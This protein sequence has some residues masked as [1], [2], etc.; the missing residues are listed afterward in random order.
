MARVLAQV[1]A[2]VPVRRFRPGGSGP[3]V[4]ARRFRLGGS[5]TGYGPEVLAQRFRHGSSGPEV[6]ARRFR[7]G[8]SSTGYGPEVP[9]QR[10]WHIRANFAT[11]SWEPL[12]MLNLQFVAGEHGL[13]GGHKSEDIRT[14]FSLN[15]NI[16]L[17]KFEYDSRLK[18][19][20]IKIVNLNSTYLNFHYYF[21]LGQ[22]EPS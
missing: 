1:P 18:A 2:R 6:P 9:A 15:F 22:A 12:A 10:F 21:K 17:K 19:D 14:F 7:H 16:Q 4:P 13:F 11:C 8:G 3:E 20:L 5:G